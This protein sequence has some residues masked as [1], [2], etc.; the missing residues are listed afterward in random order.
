MKQ[1]WDRL[2]E[3]LLSSPQVRE[4]D[5]L[6]SA[7]LVDGLSRALRFSNGARPVGHKPPVRGCGRCAAPQ[8]IRLPRMP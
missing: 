3:E 2:A 8:A 6:S 5:A 1:L 7:N 4:R